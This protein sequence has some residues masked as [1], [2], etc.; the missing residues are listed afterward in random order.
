MKLYVG[1][2]APMIT[3]AELKSAFEQCDGLTAAHVVYDSQSGRSRGFGFVE[4]DSMTN[5]ERAVSTVNGVSLGG[6]E[7]KVSV[8]TAGQDG[9]DGPEQPD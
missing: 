2:L 8:A 9:E 3:G 1:N 5:A 6:R 7:L 4:F